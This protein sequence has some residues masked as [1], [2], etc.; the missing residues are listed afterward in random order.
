MC[1]SIA[2]WTPDHVRWLIGEVSEVAGRDDEGFSFALELL[3][4][5]IDRRAHNER[6]D[7]RHWGHQRECQTGQDEPETDSAI[8][9]H[10]LP[11]CRC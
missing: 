2:A 3:A 7:E 11:D 5:L 4:L 10:V 6:R 8:V 1:R 9:C